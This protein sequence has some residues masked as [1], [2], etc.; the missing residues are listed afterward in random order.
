MMFKFSRA[1]DLACTL[2]LATLPSFAVAGTVNLPSYPLAVKSP[3]LSTWVPGNLVGDLPTAQPE[4]WAGQD[5]TWSILA[6]VNG[7]IYTL[8]GVP[9]GVSGATAATTGAA[10][11]TSSHTVFDLTAGDAAITLDFFSPV[12]PGTSDYARQSLPYSYLTVNATSTSSGEVVDVQ[13]LSGIDQTWTAQDGAADLNYTTSSTAGFFWFYNPDE[14]LFTE[15]SDMAT[16]GSVIFA[17][18]TGSAVTYACDTAAN[19][20]STFASSGSLTA[21]TTCSGSDLAAL[22]KDLGSVDSSSPGSV[23]FAV[24]FDRVH[25]IN[26]LGNSQTGYYRSKWP[27]IAGAVEYFL[28]DYDSVYATSIT[29][30]ADVRSKSEA[31]SSTFGSN[32]ADI[33]EASVRQTF[34]AIELTVSEEEVASKHGRGR[35][36]LSAHESEQQIL[37]DA[38]VNWED[39]SEHCLLTDSRSLSMISQPHL[40]YSSRKSRVMAMSILLTSYTNHGQSSSA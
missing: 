2:A 9:A 4:F 36:L 8:F 11:Y 15:S 34:G 35:E 1:I 26:Y 30:D 32:Y 33:V 24:G 27:T 17:T 5:I 14:I 7:T 23:T 19:V 22:S 12:L 13:I 10:T 31:V 40:R 6:R 37:S 38:R 39:L 16:Y 25:A 29:F 3:Y 28:G 20:Y 21:S 18:T